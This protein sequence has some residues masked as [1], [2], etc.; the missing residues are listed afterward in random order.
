MVFSPPSQL[1]GSVLSMAGQNR[2][3]FL[4][5]TGWLSSFL[6]FKLSPNDWWLEAL[7]PLFSFT[8]VY[9]NAWHEVSRFKQKW[10]ERFGCSPS[11]T[12]LWPLY[13]QWEQCLVNSSLVHEITLS[14]HIFRLERSLFRQFWGWVLSN[15]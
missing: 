5:L 8:A 13:V 15:V 2:N 14:K 11:D 10:N 3:N 12:N 6:K 9:K 7:M 4:F 1:H